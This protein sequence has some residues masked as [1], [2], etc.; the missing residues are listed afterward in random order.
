MSF[1]AEARFVT[2]ATCEPQVTSPE[3]IRRAA[4]DVQDWPEVVRLADQHGVVAFVRQS[5]ARAGVAVPPAAEAPLR[6]AWVGQVAYVMSL[7]LALERILDAFVQAN[8]PVIVLKG[9]ALART[10]YPARTLRPYG[11]VDLTV[12]EDDQERAAAALS[13]NG[14]LEA[15]YEPEI[16]RLAH[17][18]HGAEEAFHRIFVKEPQGLL[19]ELH[20]DPLQLGIKPACEAGRWERAI[21]VPGLRGALMLGYEDQVVQ[22]AVHA[23]KHA[24]G[25]LIWLKDLDLLLRRDHPLDWRIVSS[26]ARSEGVRASVW[27]A[28]RLTSSL[29]RSDMPAQARAMRPSLPVR[30]LYE[31]LW[32]ED[33]VVDLTARARWRT[34]QFRVADSWRGM[35]PTLLLMGR[36][37]DRARG[38]A[39]AI[40]RR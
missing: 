7:D 12:H 17:A 14:F 10:I 22:L 19:I 33:N 5:V 27:Y 16:A 13:A 38:L 15:P 8:I 37:R 11:D 34:V 9:P 1:A 18:D 24:F 35:L 25:R 30:K 29:L 21:A 32:T 28:L 23:H 26:V 31:L 40:L 36:R 3:Q 4:G 6:D 39:H 2:V 20:V